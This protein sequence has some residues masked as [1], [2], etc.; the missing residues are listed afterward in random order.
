MFLSALKPMLTLCEDAIA[1]AKEG[2]V[3]SA[4]GEI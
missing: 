1:L 3:Q 2:K 4:R